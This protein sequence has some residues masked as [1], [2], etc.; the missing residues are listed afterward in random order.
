MFKIL[1]FK[2]NVTL[3]WDNITKPLNKCTTYHDEL[4]TRLVSFLLFVLFLIILILWP[5]VEFP[6]LWLQFGCYSSLVIAWC[7]YYYARHGYWTS[8]AFFL[9]GITY[10]GTLGLLFYSVTEDGY[11]ELHLIRDVQALIMIIAYSQSL[12][13]TWILSIVA[14]FVL[15]TLFTI[16]KIFTQFEYRFWYHWTSMFVVTC[17]TVVFGAI[18]KDYYFNFVEKQLVSNISHE[19]R[20]PLHAIIGATELLSN[21]GAD[22]RQELL[23]TILH[24]GRDM[25]ELVNDILDFSKL[26]SGDLKI[27]NKRFHLPQHLHATVNSV[28]HLA[29]AKN[30]TLNLDI[31]TDLPAYVIGDFRRIK[32]ILLN[33][34][35]NAI[36][37]TDEGYVR[38]RVTHSKREDKFADITFHVEDSGQGITEKNLKKLFHRFERLDS[39]KPGTGLGLVICRDLAKLMGGT[40]SM[41][42]VVGKGSVFMFSIQLR[43]AKPPN[44][45]FINP[46]EKVKFEKEY[47]FILAEDN[48]LIQ[49]LTR[50]M[51]NSM[52]GK[53]FITQNGKECFEHYIQHHNEYCKYKSN[54][55]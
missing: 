47:K 29:K 15:G 51:I 22:H 28:K 40:I 26:R 52:G 33:F 4:K 16:P 5:F 34:L 10:F 21:C 49:H 24:S 39:D 11:S 32:Q 7:A 25:L 2:K 37:F 45:H 13:P 38:L 14:C 3:L 6:S 12:V 48:T 31:P 42:S 46:E 43:I 19:L 17:F 50:H 54:V 30:L 9:M 27:I 53:V 1:G 36:K 55:D 8:I 23:Q 35:S 41:R 44:T 20:T 18:V